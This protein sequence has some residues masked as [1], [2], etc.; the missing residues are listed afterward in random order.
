MEDCIDRVGSVQL[1]TKYRQRDTGKGI[2]ATD[3]EQHLCQSE[4]R[5]ENKE[6]SWGSK[7]EGG[8]TRAA[9]QKKTILTTSSWQN[10]KNAK[11]AVWTRLERGLA[12]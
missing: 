12:Y 5:G 8:K 1:V 10:N 11:L 6:N 2:T 4:Q 9:E 3:M 7:K